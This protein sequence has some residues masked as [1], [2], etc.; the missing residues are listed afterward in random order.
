VAIMQVVVLPPNE[1]GSNLLSLVYLKDKSEARGERP[2]CRRLLFPPGSGGL[3]RHTG[4][5]SDSHGFL[6]DVAVA[7]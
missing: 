4:A 5:P 1:S 6:H 3:E 7:K 2:T